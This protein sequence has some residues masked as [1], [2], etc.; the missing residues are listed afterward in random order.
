[1][2]S[3]QLLIR[4]A[5][6]AF[7]KFDFATARRSIEAFFWHY[8]TDNYL[9]MTKRRAWRNEEGKEQE[10]PTTKEG[11]ISAV[12][13]L[14]LGMNIL[15]RLLAPFAPYITEE[16]WSWT[17]QDYT[18]IHM[19]GGW[20]L[21]QELEGIRDGHEI[22]QSTR[23]A[24]LFAFDNAMAAMVA[25][26]KAQDQERASLPPPKKKQE[27]I[28]SCVPW[29]RHLSIALTPPKHKLNT[30]GEAKGEQKQKIKLAIQT[31]S[32]RVSSEEE[33]RVLLATGTLADI[34]SCF[35]FI[36]DL[37]S[38]TIDVDSA[39]SPEQIEVRCQFKH[40]VHAG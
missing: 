31:A 25:L 1:L 28:C 37:G 30:Q 13:T 12:L 5:T 22:Y 38:I 36:G 4:E 18:S 40:L 19:R 7:E 6:A 9:E 2:R 39:C 11:R 29:F 3:L 26:R 34:F 10:S 35:S 8:F 17:H 14:R 20:P 15:L 21:E 23:T 27:V 16:V 33:K 32:L 24:A